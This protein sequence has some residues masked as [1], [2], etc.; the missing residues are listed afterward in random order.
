MKR[1]VI[2][3]LVSVLTMLAACTDGYLGA[4]TPL[5]LH[6]DMTLAETL[7]AMD[8][9]G[10]AVPDGGHGFALQAHCVLQWR[11]DGDE[12]TASLLGMESALE[13][14][15]KDDLFR[16]VLTPVAAAS[17]VAGVTVLGGA[18]WTEAT[19]MKWMLD[20]VRRFC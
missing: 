16:V 19:Q 3:G 17:D 10:E 14:R 12:R 7:T 6:Y 9:V 2:T 8:R 15:P 5:R 20:H 13:S 4:E 1:W 18:P 11:A